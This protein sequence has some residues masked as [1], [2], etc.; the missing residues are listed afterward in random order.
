VAEA[1]AYFDT[2][3]FSTN[4][5]GAVTATKETALI[6]A[7]RLM[8]SMWEWS[9]AATDDVQALLWPRVGM[10]AKNELEFVPDNEIPIEL[11]NATAELAFQLIAED[12]TLDSDIESK[13]ITSLTAGPVSLS[14]GEGVTAKVVPDAVYHLIPPWWGWVRGRGRGVRRAWRT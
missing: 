12:R 11:K 3:L 4:W 6:M 8:D 7:T 9:G 13:K 1:D 5:T 10:R 2:R 14:F